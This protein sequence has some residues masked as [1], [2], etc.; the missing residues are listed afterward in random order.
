MGVPHRWLVVLLSL[1]AFGAS[2]ADATKRGDAL[3][4]AEVA[5]GVFVHA[6]AQEEVTAAN[7]GAIANTG[8]V[9]GGRCVA[10]VDTGGSLNAG[11]AL[12][13]A[14][15]T[16]TALPICYVI[17]THGHPDHVFGNGAFLA[18]KPK[19]L[20]H[21]KLP[22]A[23]AAR[24]QGFLRALRR[25]LG[26]GAAGSTLVPPDTL[27]SD[28]LELDLGERKL[29]LR[30]WKT[31]HTDN[32]VTVYDEKTETLWLGDLLF[33]DRVPVVD[34]SL[35]G[36][37]DVIK[38]LRGMHVAHAVPGHGA[39]QDAWP[40]PLDAEDHY[41]RVLADDVR[42]ALRKRLTLQQ[43]VDSVGTGERGKW[44]LFDNYNKRNVTAAYAE[45]EWED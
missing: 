8:F 15:K 9:V 41:L 35:R 24:E 3:S 25:D 12:R 38:E 37:L 44:L 14:I 33:V 11:Q 32:D 28:V 19:F 2:A 31:A 43:T 45:L 36:W 42:A 6:G 16:R 18:D 40:A 13:D 4:I 20:G 17:N 26:D 27:V 29:T 23:L 30:A 39:V 1:L 5:A 21:A 10:V 22:H 34:G 7:L